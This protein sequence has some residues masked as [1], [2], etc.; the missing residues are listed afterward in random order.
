MNEMT[1][2][3]EGTKSVGQKMRRMTGHVENTTAHPRLTI[4]Q[5]MKVAAKN[6]ATQTVVD[7]IAK[8]VQSSTG[9]LAEF[10]RRSKTTGGVLEN[11]CGS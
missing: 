10:R 4:L 1:Q 8:V 3:L 2:P 5:D 9:S 6:V 11:R 7:T